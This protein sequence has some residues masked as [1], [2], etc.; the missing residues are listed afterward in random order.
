M[1]EGKFPEDA[2]ITPQRQILASSTHK[3]NP[4]QS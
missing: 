1:I 4:A 3:A 2:K